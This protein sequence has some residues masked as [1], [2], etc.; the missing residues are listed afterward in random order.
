MLFKDKLSNLRQ[1]LG[2][3]QKAVADKAKMSMLTYRNYEQGTRLPGLPAFM[4]LVQALNVPCEVFADC[5]DIADS[6]KESRLAKKLTNRR[7]RPPAKK[8]AGARR[9]RP[10]KGKMI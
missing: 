9:G 8:T 7:G 1:S 3:T 2:L 6:D 10:R 4:K 5:E